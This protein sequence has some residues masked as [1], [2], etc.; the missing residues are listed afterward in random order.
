VPQLYLYVQSVKCCILTVNV[1]SWGV[2]GPAAVWTGKML[3]F[4]FQLAAPKASCVQPERGVP[5]FGAPFPSSLLV[6]LGFRPKRCWELRGTLLSCGS[7]ACAGPGRCSLSVCWRVG[8]PGAAGGACNLG[9]AWWN[10]LEDL[11][12]WEH[13][14]ETWVFDFHYICFCTCVA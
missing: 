14:F 7:R 3:H 5:R 6:Q 9:A 8:N 10:V 4:E 11:K 13:R 1:G 2:L 12:S